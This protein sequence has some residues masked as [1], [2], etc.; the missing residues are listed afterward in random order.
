MG[1]LGLA[2]ASTA[3]PAPRTVYCV[4]AVVVWALAI[5]GI[6]VGAFPRA[7]I[8][9]A[10]LLAGGLLAA[11]T[12]LTALS[13]LWTSDQGNTFDQIARA[14]GY[15]GLFVLVTLASKDGEGGWWLRGLTIGLIAIAA[16]A[17]GPRLLPDAFG[18]PDASLGAQ[19][20]I[21]FPIRYWNGLAALMAFAAVLTTWLS[22]QAATRSGRSLAAAAIVLPIVVLYMAQSRGGALALIGGFAVLLAVGPARERLA[23]SV[24]LSGLMA[25]PLI[26][27]IR[28][29]TAFLDKPA[30]DLAA[31]QGPK[32]LIYGLVTLAVIFVVRR[33]LDRRLQRFELSRG[34]AASC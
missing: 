21:G 32:V 22:V 11:F 19:G 28:T 33:A 6:L 14:G 34:P 29:Q 16:V 31:N 26:G 20:R 9:R 17:L 2:L 24:V 5:V 7:P 8:P 27:F 30:S 25:L 12:G 3:A 10:A 13:L 1:T 18:T 23:A 4:A 15:T